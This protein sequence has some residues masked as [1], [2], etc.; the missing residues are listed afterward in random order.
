M[1]TPPPPPPPQPQATSSS[2]SSSSLVAKVA[3]V[4]Q[5]RKPPPAAAGLRLPASLPVTAAKAPQTAALHLPASFHIAPGTVLLRSNTGQLMLVS[6]QALVQ[7]Q[8][9]TQSNTTVRWSIPAH[10][11]VV[12]IQTPQ[13]SANQV[14]KVL[15]APVK[16]VSQTTHSITSGVKKTAVIQSVASTNSI[17][18]STTLKETSG[19]HPI[20]NFHVLPAAPKSVRDATTI[21]DT[22]TTV[23]QASISA[24]TLEN[25]KKCKNFLA[26]L[27]KLASNGPH[28]PEMGQNVKNLVE[29]LLEAKIEPEEFTKKLYIELK[30]SP[31]PYLVPFL[32]KS[33]HALRHLTPDIQTFI[34]QC[35]QQ[36]IPRTAA[37]TCA[38][39]LS[40]A[41]VVASSTPVTTASFQS[42]RPVLRTPL[43]ISSPQTLDPVSCTSLVTRGS[44]SL[45]FAQP[46]G[47]LSVGTFPLQVANSVPSTHLA[48]G[49]DTLK[50]VQPTSSIAVMTTNNTLIQLTKPVHTPATMFSAPL[51]ALSSVKSVPSPAVAKSPQVGKSALTTSATTAFTKTV[52]TALQ[53]RAPVTGKPITIRVVH[54]N[55]VISQSVQTSQAVKVKQL[56]VQQPSGN[57]FKKVSTFQQ[58]SALPTV[59]K[60]SGKMPLNTVI[61]AN[62]LPAGSI[63]KQITL[64]GNKI[65][66]LQASPVQRNKIRANGTTSFRDED[67]IN[68]VASMAGV[69]LNEESACILATNSEAVGVVIRSCPEELLL[70]SDALQKKI[71]E[72]GKRHGITEVNSDVLNLISYATQG[73]LRGLLEKLTVIAQHRMMTY[74]ESD[75]YTISSDTRAQLRFLEQ[76]D[77][78]EKQRKDEEERERL[79]RA[80]KSRSNK[81]DP[82]QL[83]LKQK[84]KEEDVNKGPCPN[85][86]F[87]FVSNLTLWRRNMIK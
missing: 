46:D 65:L 53:S 51:A 34:Q 86:S 7:A 59:N 45:Q 12:K 23:A 17:T 75:K 25:V 41:S 84:A 77:H 37:S 28:S 9:Q 14:L 48:S 87:N 1:A 43:G 35:L 42:A 4:S 49:I 8:S 44:V 80:A 72:I 5:P 10:S 30:S 85:T 78:V 3:P 81:E 62:Q 58:A 60:A 64:P 18:T 67:D 22:A 52:T 15:A 71:L 66:S 69:N 47:A 63:V 2:S 33:V 6:Q 27:I 74:K 38:A 24:E 13:N 31:Q 16:T 76:L 19:N 56:I 39:A 82:E 40:S 79:F 83:R 11:S 50:T 73:R 26:T 21:H 54:P 36:S 29:N 68:D 32:K 55:S 57:I 20:S 61:H 70:S